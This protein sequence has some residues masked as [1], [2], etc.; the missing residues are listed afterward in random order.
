VR[1]KQLVYSWDD[2]GEID[3]NRNS[4]MDSGRCPFFWALV[5]A[6]AGQCLKCDMLGDL[7]KGRTSL[8]CAANMVA[9][10]DQRRKSCH[11]R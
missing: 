7:N 3:T 11:G 9:E 5:R 1:E 4:G 8:A 2:T 6:V 10:I